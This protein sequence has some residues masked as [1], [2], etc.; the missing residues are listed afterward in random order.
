MKLYTL[1]VLL[2]LGLLNYGVSYAQ[3]DVDLSKYGIADNANNVLGGLSVGTVAPTF[4]GIDQNGKEISLSSLLEKGPL[5][6]L[7]YRGEW[8]PIC[9]RYLS[10]LQED[11]GRIT[12]TGA[13]VLAV[14]PETTEY[15]D[16]TIE[17]SELTIPVLSD[18]DEH[19]MQDYKV[20]FT[21]TAAYQKKIRRFLRTDIAAQNGADTANLPI[22]ATYIIGQDG[23]I[24][25]V[26][27]DPNY[28]KR[29]SVDDILTALEAL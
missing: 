12:Q 2:T 21:V 15:I 27:Y 29:A 4:E 6:L 23:R 26:H 11:L 28:K 24:Q 8:C 5:V 16:E 17:K 14:S 22:P 9:N 7:F 3:V 10:E 18:K 1:L 25:Y 20:S 13:H 19:I